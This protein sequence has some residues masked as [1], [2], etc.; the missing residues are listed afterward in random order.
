MP[1]GVAMP[2]RVMKPIGSAIGIPDLTASGKRRWDALYAEANP[3]PPLHG[4]LHLQLFMP[5]EH[6]REASGAR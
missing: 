5:V 2:N 4:H 6:Y 1:F 3:S